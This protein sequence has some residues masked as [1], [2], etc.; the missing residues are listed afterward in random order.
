MKLV[1]ELV[2][3]LS[4]VQMERFYLKLNFFF[5]LHFS[6]PQFQVE[7]LRVFDLFSFSII[8]L[9]LTTIKIKLFKN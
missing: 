3:E 1:T 5:R 7:L 9:I 8:F 4:V 2:K 6:T